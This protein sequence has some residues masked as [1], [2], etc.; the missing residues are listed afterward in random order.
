MLR[1]ANTQMAKLCIKEIFSSFLFLK[2][3]YPKIN[4]DAASILTAVKNKGDEESTAI[5]PKGK[6]QDQSVN[7]KNGKKN[8]NIPYPNQKDYNNDS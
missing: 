4:K 1:T 7:N 6:Q 5:L 3:K 2:N 8:I